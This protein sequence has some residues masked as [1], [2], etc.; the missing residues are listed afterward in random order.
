MI[1][2][3]VRHHNKT[4]TGEEKVKSQAFFFQIVRRPWYVHT[5][6]C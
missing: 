2:S 6:T 5:F 1:E 3:S 4:T